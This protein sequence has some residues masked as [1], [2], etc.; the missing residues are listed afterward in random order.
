MCVAATC[1][2]ATIIVWVSLWRE[3][4]VKGMKQTKGLTM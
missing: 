3:I 4:N 1:L 2:Y